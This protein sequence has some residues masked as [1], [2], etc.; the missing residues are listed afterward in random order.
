MN[1]SMKILLIVLA[2]ISVIAIVGT[3][4]LNHPC[5]GRRMSRERKTRIEESPNYRN[6]QFQNQVPT[7]QFTGDKSMFKALW[8]FLSE[9]KKDRVPAEAVPA[10]KTDLKALTSGPSTPSTG[11]GTEDS[12]TSGVGK[13]WLVWFGH[14]SYLFCLDGKRYLVDPVLKMEFPVSVMMHPFKGTD[15]YSPDDMPEVDVLIITHEHWDHLD[16]ATLRDLKD[17]VKHVVCPL[18]VAEYLE[19]WGYDPQNITEMDWYET[20]NYQL[21]TISCLPTRHFSNRLF[22]RNQTL[23][24]SFIVESGGRKVY[25]GG[26]GGYD[27]RFKEIHE[28]FG[29][30]DLALMENGQ[31]NKDWANIHLMPK[32]LEQAILDLQPKQVF[33]LHHDKFSLAPHA[34]T[35]PD[36]VAYDI[37]ERNAIR[38]LDQP[39]GTVVEF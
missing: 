15:I 25:I 12:G 16:Y 34:W 19:Y 6:G 1:K 13:D 5:F 7:P 31:Y 37:A 38:L 17:K 36:S 32:D 26:D 28:R 4:I 20:I 27:G 24:A 10:M 18:G 30:V 29:S 14:S 35:E 22:K 33:T 11:S 39:I 23:W 8:K 9:N 3:I 21:T 2:V